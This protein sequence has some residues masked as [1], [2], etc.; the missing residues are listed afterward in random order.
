MA[1]FTER[2]RA[3]LRK[4]VERVEKLEGR[5]TI[6]EPISIT[7]L[8]LGITRTLGD[9]GLVQ[10]HGGADALERLA[11]AQHA[12]QKPTD[13][14]HA[15]QVLEPN[16]AHSFVPIAVSRHQDAASAGGSAG[17]SSP[18]ATA[19][20]PRAST[21]QN[22]G[23]WLSLSPSSSAGSTETGISTPWKPIRHDGGG[24][25][26]PGHGGVPAASASSRISRGGA[27][28]Q[29]QLAPPAPTTS[30][31][32]A[33]GALLAAVAGASAGA[34]T[35]A[36]APATAAGATGRRAGTSSTGSHAPASPPISVSPY[37][38][39][40]ATDPSGGGIGSSPGIGGFSPPYQPS[41][42]YFAMYVLDNN[43]GVVLYPGVDQLATLNGSVDLL[44]QVSGTTVSSYN[45]NTSG[46]GADIKNLSVTNTYQLT[47]QWQNAFSTTHTDSVTLSVTDVSSHTESY[48]YDFYLPAGSTSGNQSGGGSN[49]TWPSSLPP[50]AQLDSSPAFDGDHGTVDATS[51]AVDTEIDLPSYNPNVAAIALTYDSLTADPRPI[52]LFEHPI[53][54]AQ[55]VPSKVSAQLT[56]DSSGGTTWYYSSSQLNGGDVEQIALQASPTSLSTGRYSYSA[57]IVDY[58]TTN[59]TITV[60]GSADVINNSASSFG[61][62]WTLQ[63]LEHITT[64]TGGVILDVGDGGRS[65]WFTGS[66]GS[67]GGTYTDPAG[68]FST[69]TK[70]NGSGGATYSRT[71]TDGTQ[72]KFNSN[73]YE[74]A[75]VDL[76][77][78]HTTFSYN[79]SNQLS[80]IEDAYGNYTTFTY[81][82]SYLQK[83]TDPAGRVTTF[84]MS[85]GSLQSVQQAD[86]SRVTY[87]YDAGGR[88]T[89]TTDALSH[90]LTV[91]YD[92]AERVAT[93][94]LPGGS[95][96]TYTNDQ[97]SGW[98]NSGTSGSPAA[99]TLLAT[100]AS[101][102]TT[103]NGNTSNLQ[104]DWLGLGQTGVAIDALGDVDTYDLNSNGLATVAIDGLNRITQFAYDS[105]GNTVT[106]VNADGTAEQFTYNSYAEP[107]TYSDENGHVTSYGY[108]THGNLTSIENA[109]GAFTTMTYTS[110][111]RVAT[112]VDANNHTTSF[113]YDSQDRVTTVQ[114][115]DSTTNLY[116]YNS[117][118]EVSKFTDGRGNATT[119]SYDALN[120][121][122]GTTDALGGVTSYVYD[123]AGNLTEVDAPTPGG[124]TARDTLYAYDSMNR[125]TTMTDALG[126]HTVYARDADGNVTS[127]K[128]PLGRIT[129]F[130]FDALDRQT[131]VVDPLGG[132]TTTTYDADSEATQTVDPL[133]RTTTM[134]YNTRGW[135]APVTDPLGHI[136]T[137]GY[138]STGQ[139][140]S[141]TLPGPS[142]G[143]NISYAY[144]AADEVVSETDANSNT[145]SFT[146]DSG[147]NTIAV[148]DANSNTTSY[149]YDSMNRLT[150]VTDGLGHTTVFG[151]NG[152][153]DQTTVKDGLGH[154]T[155]T[156]YDALNRPTTITSAVGGNTVIAYDVAGREISLTD[157]V[158]NETQWAYD[159]DDRV[160]TMTLP[161]G[162]TVTYSYN[163]DSELID[164]T[165]ADGRRTTYAY[166][167]DGDRTGET[168]VNP[169]G[170]SPL[171]VITYRYDADNELTGA[172]DSYAT[173]TFTYDSGGNQL[174]AATSGPGSGQPSITLTS[175]YNAQNERTNLSDNLSSAGS[176]TFAYDAGERLTTITTSYGGTAG[177]QVVYS[178]D[179]A[180]RMTS[181]VRTVGG[182]GTQVISSFNYDAA[183]RQTTIIHEAYTPSSGGGT[184]TG[185]ATYVYSYDSANRVTSEQDA[186]GTASFTYDNA[187]ELTGVTGSRSESYSYDSNGNRNSTGYTTTT[188]NEQT[189][190]PGHSYGY[191]N[192][193]N[194]IS[195]T[196]TSTHIITTYTYDYRNRVT[197]VNVGGTVVATYVYDAIDRR[198]GI[199]D[200][201]TQTWTVYDGSSPDAHP[202]AD[203]NG[204]GPLTE[205]YLW[206]PGVVNGAAVD[207]LLA[208]TSSGGST[209]WYLPDKL[210][211]VRD[212]VDGSGSA[213]NH[214]V[215]DSFGN[216][217][218]E[219][220]PSNGD[221]FKF[222]GMEYDPA[223]GQYYDRARMYG[224][225]LGRFDSEDPMM[226]LS[227]I[228]NLYEYV[229]N[230]PLSD[231]DR[232]G[233]MPQAA[234]KQLEAIKKAEE[235]LKKA[236]NDLANEAKFMSE[237]QK[238]AYDAL[239]KLYDDK[240]IIIQK[241]DTPETK[242]IENKLVVIIPPQSV[243]EPNRLQLTLFHESWHVLWNT[244][245]NCVL[246]ELDAYKWQLQWYATMRANGIYTSEE[247]DGKITDFN[248]K[249]YIAS[250]MKMRPQLPGYHP[251]Y[252]PEFKPT[253]PS[254]L[255]PPPANRPNAKPD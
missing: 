244:P 143:S 32:G 216:V 245:M 154:T 160:T 247:F 235:V 42:P 169:S 133:G 55:A 246:E 129:T 254:E 12:A 193:G 118:G 45:W 125:V 104:P 68:E 23:D 189:A 80:S 179:A 208:R 95:S 249:D 242:P 195:D 78:L 131:V 124:Q 25:V 152:D 191:D 213:L 99:P 63:G 140:S 186:E 4:A 126:N 9:L 40:G 31:S 168:W 187:N 184:V 96:E 209:A 28:T 51:G 94:S 75:I 128:D 109:L 132:R 222:A 115:P 121:E 46:L 21:G 226:F 6:T 178:Y 57:T 88:M 105:K 67:G 27:I 116:T 253:P 136:T 79:G 5:N 65:L 231:T 182:A 11:A 219:S 84:T 233:L 174:T 223:T 255:P 26:L 146:Y 2:R 203:F 20:D 217:L 167:A 173:L 188:G 64:A 7:A 159:A 16:P 141:V 72:I 251:S 107:L 236:M 89:Q 215:Y 86:G 56:F 230:A 15:T 149:A 221:R 106:I 98:T 134:G 101:T 114:F 199:K 206:G 41:F 71:L 113:Q 165:D 171:D 92:S 85:S 90:T 153:G 163:A 147:G 117:Q 50:D 150:T 144:N 250:Y 185:L 82:G 61:D 30:G 227:S 232:S 44:A 194:L 54:P 240:R 224:P 225:A 52:V 62:G 69:L 142:G 17:Q 196:N 205:R 183:N 58:R 123:S 238:R 120:R 175:T 241:H 207:E 112:H 162:H 74:T 135:V 33:A 102:F 145:T 204:S 108:D 229:G 48:T 127:V 10:V 36:P 60:S 130:V 91:S 218:S 34:G 190:S 59:T 181:I 119:M 201:G 151:Y 97:E 252:N 83:V 1:S 122:T 192:A 243:V 237:R 214:V 22:A 172:S 239:K 73:G 164:S 14:A 200:N 220:S 3:R 210:G 176:T 18:A 38:D 103:P 155:T 138:T 148:K 81:S 212:I 110:T 137:Y 66:F 211:S 35:Q 43:N 234:Q 87:A 166:D 39:P 197:A 248:A 156:L 37:S 180:N 53:D 76:N 139:T 100:A 158:G 24:P 161:N 13:H 198:I 19:S 77:G 202:Y 29:A 177:P 157:S 111:G 49:V 8:S 70:M 228:F 93:I 47:W 170:G